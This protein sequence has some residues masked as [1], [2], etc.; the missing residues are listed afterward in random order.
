MIAGL[1]NLGVVHTAISLWPL[2]PASSPS[3]AT[4]KSAC[5]RW[6]LVA[7]AVG[8]AAGTGKFG[9]APEL[10]AATGV[11]LALF[12]VGVA[13]QI[14]RLRGQARLSPVRVPAGS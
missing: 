14:V 9:T 4:R 2:R 7:L 6:P 10:K 13:L 3:R 1:T 12:L 8:W 5:A 11:L